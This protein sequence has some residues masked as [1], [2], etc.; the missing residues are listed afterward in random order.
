MDCVATAGFLLLFRTEKSPPEG[1][2]QQRL[3]G[4]ERMGNLCV[5][6]CDAAGLEGWKFCFCLGPGVV[7]PFMAHSAVAVAVFVASR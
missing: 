4:G 6:V 1:G 2:S 3:G 5:R 7:A